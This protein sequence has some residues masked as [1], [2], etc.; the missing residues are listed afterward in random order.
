MFGIISNTKASITQEKLSL[1]NSQQAGQLVGYQTNW[2]VGRQQERL[3]LC[4]S[5][6]V[7]KFRPLHL[8]STLFLFFVFCFF[9]C[10]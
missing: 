1:K 7:T 8:C 2:P 9:H 5:D 4:W 6:R 10:L 3:F